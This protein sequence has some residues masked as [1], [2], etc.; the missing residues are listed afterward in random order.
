MFDQFQPGGATYELLR[1]SLQAAVPLWI[2]RFQEQAQH[3][4]QSAM[5]DLLIDRAKECSKVIAEKGDNILFRSE[6]KGETADAFN[7]LAEGIACLSFC[8][9]GV[10]IFQDRYQAQL[11]DQ[12]MPSEVAEEL[13]KVYGTLVCEPA[14]AFDPEFD[15]SSKD[16]RALPQSEDLP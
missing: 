4:P 16:K 5:W 11:Y 13:Q 12:E 15:L 7:H 2:M 9:G 10:K 6:K 1:I 14:R 8:P 3:L